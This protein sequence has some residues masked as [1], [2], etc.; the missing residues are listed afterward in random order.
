MLNLKVHKVT[1]RL[2]RVN[3]ASIYN[4]SS[5]CFIATSPHVAGERVVDSC[6]ST[7]TCNDI[8]SPTVETKEC[9]TPL[10]GLTRM[11]LGLVAMKRSSSNRKTIQSCCFYVAVEIS[12]PFHLPSLSIF[13]YWYFRDFLNRTK[14]KCS[15]NRTRTQQSFDH[16]YS[17]TTTSAP[18]VFSNRINCIN[19]EFLLK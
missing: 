11:Q 2:C 7:E 19:N 17:H 13:A 3:L 6:S 10:D 15:A 8:N 18:G 4:F 14:L 16:T 9:T 12:T 5:P 1:T